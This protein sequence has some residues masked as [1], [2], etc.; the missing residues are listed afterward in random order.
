MNLAVTGFKVLVAF[1]LFL[2]FATLF[3]LNRS[4]VQFNLRL[5]LPFLF[6]EIPS[7]SIVNHLFFTSLSVINKLEMSCTMKKGAA[8]PIL[9]AI[10]PT[11][12]NR[13]FT[14]SPGVPAE[15]VG[16]GAPRRLM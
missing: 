14:L 7:L 1:D 12:I 11:D 13:L 5:I 15:R 3:V 2:F 10:I 9:L 4:I 6:T 8:R 16:G